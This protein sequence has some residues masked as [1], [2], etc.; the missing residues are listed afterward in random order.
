AVI[1]D[2]SPPSAGIVGSFS[3]R[4]QERF[5][6]ITFGDRNPKAG[7]QELPGWEDCFRRWFLS[8]VRMYARSRWGQV[9]PANNSLSSQAR[10][11]CPQMLLPQRTEALPTTLA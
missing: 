2:S 6:T 7:S 8:P 11:P 3:V 1:T 4:W 9:P 10:G 5:E